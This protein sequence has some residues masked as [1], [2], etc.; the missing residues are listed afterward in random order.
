MAMEFSDLD[1]LS[2]PE[3]ETNGDAFSAGKPKAKGGR[4]GEP[5]K[6]AKATSAAGRRRPTKQS[7]GGGVSCGGSCRV[8]MSRDCYNDIVR[9]YL[10]YKLK[11]G[12]NLSMKDFIYQMVVEGASGAGIT[13]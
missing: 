1:V 3:S 4:K 9:L 6:A 8:Y 10:K 11:N 7:G 12:C 13:I 2:V 5:K